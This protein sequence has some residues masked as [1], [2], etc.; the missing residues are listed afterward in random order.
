[1]HPK[2]QMSVFVSMTVPVLVSKSSGARYGS[3]ECSAARSWVWRAR[4]REAM[5][6]GEGAREPRSIRMGAVPESEIMMLPVEEGVLLVWPRR[7][8]QGTPRIFCVLHEHTRFYISMRISTDFAIA[9]ALLTP[10]YFAI[11]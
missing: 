1:M 4:A 8:T 10:R 6:K 3:V 2:D 5:C 11:H 9:D 7:A